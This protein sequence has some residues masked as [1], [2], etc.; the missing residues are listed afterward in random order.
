M[1]SSSSIG[2]NLFVRGGSYESKP[3]FSREGVALV[4][5]CKR[6]SAA[7]ST[8]LRRS[9]GKVSRLAELIIVESLA[10]AYLFLRKN[11]NGPFPFFAPDPLDEPA[12]VCFDSLSVLLDATDAS[13]G[14]GG[15]GV[16]SLPSES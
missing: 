10:Y 12:E 7:G 6:L 13:G 3:A 16:E 11:G 5:S 2:L 4:G 9:K 1:T 15:G 14:G 8:R